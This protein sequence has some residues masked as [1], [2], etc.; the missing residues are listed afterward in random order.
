MVKKESKLQAVSIALCTFNGERFLKEQLESILNQDYGN[1]DEIIC[2]DDNSKD[3]TWEIL[4]DYA[5]KY[6]IFKI[7][8][9]LSNLGFV[10]NYEKA[11]TLTSNPL[12]AI[13][14]Q[15]D[16]WYSNKIS[17]LVNS[18]G[19]N[20]MSYSDNNYIDIN[21]NSLGKKFSDKRN[22]TTNTSCLNFA[23]F[24]AMSGHTILLNRDL[25]QHSLPFPKEIPYDFWLAFQASQYGKIQVVTEALVGYRQHDNNTIGAIGAKK[26]RKKAGEIKTADKTP[27]RVQIFAE[28]MAPVLVKEQIILKQ[29]GDT[30]TSRSIKNRLKRV[31]ILW[32][33]REAILLFKKTNKFRKMFFCLKVFWKFE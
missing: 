29:L 14:D 32:N 19:N 23:L 3:T 30:Y 15:D 12:I 20:I 9:N 33:N 24:N 13:S 8:Q 4:K 10:K 7:Y 17:S 26:Y 31:A 22:L 6:H 16:I 5:A 27:N 21:G 1:I 28:N 11:I 18:I 25:L 2:V